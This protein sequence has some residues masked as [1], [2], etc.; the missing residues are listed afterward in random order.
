M[1]QSAVEIF[2]AILAARSWLMRWSLRAATIPTDSHKQGE[3]DA[4]DE[5][6]DAGIVVGSTHKDPADELSSQTRRKGEER[7]GRTSQHKN[8]V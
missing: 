1:L 5:V 4:K 2:G 3:G 8:F 7:E 6:P